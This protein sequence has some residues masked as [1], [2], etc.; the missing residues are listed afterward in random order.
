MM[1][2]KSTL[3]RASIALSLVGGLVGCGSDSSTA[4][5][6]PPLTQAEA[7]NVAT[8]LF[9]EMSKALGKAGVSTPTAATLSVAG[10]PGNS[11]SSACT[12]GGTISGSLNFTDNVNSQGTGTVSGSTNI[13]ATGCKVST[14]TKVIAIDG[15]LDFTFSMALTQFAPSGNAT[16]HTVGSFTWDGGSCSTDFTVTITPQGKTTIA[17]TVC[18]QP[19]A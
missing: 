5:K 3:V 19:V 11:L 17:G 14:G 2:R 6:N 12:N 9:G 4:P 16:F 18:G 15:S 10:T 7:K 13:T 1:R 8:A